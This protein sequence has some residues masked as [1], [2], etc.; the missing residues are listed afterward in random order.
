MREKIRMVSRRVEKNVGKKRG[1]AKRT[2]QDK[3]HEIRRSFII[4]RPVR[5]EKLGGPFVDLGSGSSGPTAGVGIPIVPGVAFCH[6]KAVK[7]N[8]ELAYCPASADAP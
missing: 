3:P 7:R 5:N 6:S 8:D 4:R 2:A 1:K